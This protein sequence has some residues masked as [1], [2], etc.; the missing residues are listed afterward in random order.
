MAAPRIGLL[1]PLLLLLGAG[2]CW[3]LWNPSQIAAADVQEKARLEASIAEASLQQGQAS[4]VEEA[5]VKVERVQQVAAPIFPGYIEFENDSNWNQPLGT[6]D[7]WIYYRNGRPR[8]PFEPFRAEEI[9]KVG[10][11]M[12]VDGSQLWEWPSAEDD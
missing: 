4:G 10:L 3:V 9:K 7:V 11:H 1:L 8:D 12:R 5:S 6:L 2:A